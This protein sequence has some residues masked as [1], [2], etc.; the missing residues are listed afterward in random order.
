M[1]STSIVK[2]VAD[3]EHYYAAKDNYYTLEEGVEQSE[4]YGKGSQRLNLQ[5]EVNPDQFTA[6]LKG[7]LPHG[8]I[9]GKI[10]DGKT[11]HRAG[12]DLTFSAPKSVSI[13]ALV[14][15]DKRLLAAHRQAVK[16]VLSDIER[17]CSEVRIKTHGNIAY[18]R[19]S[20]MIAALFHH[21]L[22]RAEDPQLHTHSVIMNL[23]ER[24]DGKWRSMS[25]KL[26][27]YDK[28]STNEI[29]GFI[30]RVRHSKRFY[31]KMYETELAYQVQQLGYEIVID[32]KTGVFQIEGISKEILD[33]F[34][35]R[36]QKIE[37]HMQ[38]QGFSGQKSAEIA[39][40]HTR[41][42]KSHVN[43]EVLLEKWKESAK[44]L[45]FNGS[46]L[47]KEA[48]Q[49]ILLGH[50]Q[51]HNIVEGTSLKN[52]QDS[53]KAITQ[54]KSTFTLDD[55]LAETAS[56]VMKEA[57]N[58]QSFLDGVD[59]LIEKGELLS[60]ENK[61]GKSFFMAKSTLDDEKRI[62]TFLSVK[63]YLN[64]DQ[65]KKGFERF[66]SKNLPISTS[67]KEALSTILSHGEN[68]ESGKN[69]K[70]V[71]I[72][73]QHAK[74]VLSKAIA[75]VAK[76][77]KWSLTIVSPNQISSKEFAL[78]LKQAPGT[79]FEKLKSLFVDTTI[80]H[81]ST[82]Q[83]LNQEGSK[84]PDIL[85]ID[86]AHLL[87]AKEQA[88]LLEWGGQQQTKL[89]FFSQKN[90]LLSQKVGVDTNY[91]VKHGIS[92]VTLPEKT[93]NTLNQDISKLDIT[94][95]IHKMASNIIDV[96][97][98][99][100]RLLAMAT[101]FVSL[102]SSK[103]VF[104]IGNNKHTVETLNQSAHRELRQCGKLQQ[105][106]MVNVLLP[107][108]VAENKQHQLDS[109]P[110]GHVIRL[111]DNDRI[112]HIRRGEYL[113]IIGQDRDQKLLLLK[114]AK[115][116]V[117]KWKPNQKVEL[118]K[119]Q[120]IEW[121]VGERL[122]SQ[123]SM[124]FT[125]VTKGEYFTISH[126]Q[127][128]KVKLTRER[129]KPL[130]LDVSKPYHR[131]FNYGYAATPHQLVHKK[132]DHF[133]ADLTASAFTTDQ[134]RFFQLVSQPN[135]VSLY[136]DDAKAL[137]DILNKKSGNKLTA[138]EIVQSSEDVRKNLSSL[139][140][141]LTQAIQKP[142]EN[143]HLLPKRAVEA[144]D[145]AIQHLAERHAGF[146]H[147]D[148]L[149]VAMTHAI[150]EVNREQLLQ[151]FQ[152]MEQA[153]ILSQKRGYNGTLWTTQ[154]AIKIEQEILALSLKDKGMLQPIIS[155]DTVHQFL[156][157]K[158]LRPE[159]LSAIKTITQ[160]HDRVLVIQGRAGTG[161]TTMMASLADI[162]SAKELIASEGYRLQGIAPTHKAVKELQSRQIPAQTIDRFLLEMRQLQ[163]SNMKGGNKFNE[164]TQDF[165][166]TILI[167]D[168]ASMVSNKKMLAILS[169]VH[170]FNFRQVIPTGDTEQLAAIEAGKPHA[171]LQR[172][173][174][175]DVIHLE[176]IQRQ[177][178]PILK[179]AVYELYK[180]EVKNTFKI[181]GDSVIEIN[182]T[183]H[184]KNK[185]IKT[186]K[187]S[188]ISKGN[189]SIHPENKTIYQARVKALVQDYLQQIK[190]SEEVQIITPSHEDRKAV[191]AEVRNQLA[192]KG[193][194]T[195]DSHAFR[196]L[197]SKDMTAIERSEI[198]NFK[199]GQILRFTASQGKT[200]K[201]GEYFVVNSIDVKH[202]GFVLSKVSDIHHKDS[203]SG[204]IFWR[205]PASSKRMNNTI[206][207]FNKEERHLK[208]GD[209]IVWVR[210]D[211][212]ENILSTDSA[213]VKEI[214]GKNITV[215]RSDKSIFTFDAK[216]EKYQHWD[217]A[218]AITAYG[219]Q[220]GT[221]S[222]VLALFESYRK[223][224]MNLKTFLVT[225][226]RA[227]NHLRIYTDHKEKLID[228]I[229]RNK[230]DKL[231]SL[232][233]IGKYPKLSQSKSVHKDRDDKEQQKQEKQEKQEKQVEENI[234]ANKR[235]EK[236]LSRGRNQARQNP[237]YP[238][239]D[240]NRIKEGLNQQAEKLAI[241]IMGQ[242]KVH[243]GSYLK[244]GSNKGSLSVTIKGEKAG[245]WNDFADS[246]ANGRSMLSFI[247]KQCGMSKREAIVYA[248]R[249]LGITPSLSTDPH[250]TMI[251][252][253]LKLE[254]AFS[255]LSL[256]ET[257][258]Q[259]KMQ[260]RAKKIAQESIS[261]Q[262]TLAEKY[263]KEYR[264]IESI[265]GI[266]AHD[267]RFHPGVYSAINKQKLP[268]L[269]GI[270]RNH[271]NEILAVEATYLDIKTG[272]KAEDLM[273]GKQTFGAKKGG[274]VLIQAGEP[275]APTLLTEGIVT[276]LSVAKALPNVTVK[277]VLGIKLFKEIDPQLLSSKVVFALDNDGNNLKTDKLIK[278]AATRLLEHKK[279]V[280]FMVP[281]NIQTSKY[282]YN[283]VLTLKGEGA[284]QHDFKQA[285]PYHQ[286]YK[287]VN[288]DQLLREGIKTISYE[289]DKAQQINN[290]RQKGIS[291][292]DISHFANAMHK[293]ME[294]KNKRINLGYEALIDKKI[295]EHTLEI[296]HKPTQL[297]RDL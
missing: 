52:I 37:K 54:F 100:T 40:L 174:E 68:G 228:Q 125:N 176:D 21:D 141:I 291:T 76:Q 19:T 66:I 15:G 154:E 59:A 253:D 290:I 114:S 201:A 264:G 2:N 123:R 175:K 11:Y 166:K 67:E 1:L 189:K 282:D 112:S 226:T 227:Q 87:S 169:L 279:E 88:D 34:S 182:D 150:G 295:V 137:F 178:N 47:I 285:A 145:Y 109:Y 280:S 14:A 74:E 24:A 185:E 237:A 79:L 138:H 82:I 202:N 206:E 251:K 63:N 276:G 297:E 92:Q 172:S 56:G 103:N 84:A 296:T 25:S 246:E 23:T 98:Q 64:N 72:E 271:Q 292:E 179:E 207:V 149:E 128:T 294:D 27:R 230:G 214:N 211:K 205:L 130:L 121:S 36:R 262:G 104:L 62:Q 200:I 239:Y 20:N 212:K 29:H 45:D 170:E 97:E 43:R 55:L 53:I 247:E 57:H 131:H 213:E 258:H 73:G 65:L 28:E 51:N 288:S 220:G 249:W 157:H 210:T 235:T 217:H 50:K 260:A 199:A 81:A 195:G 236:S 161:K 193:F 111:L 209:K 153:G 135:N 229:G 13:M 126:I 107:Q 129:G 289:W 273:V 287:E 187:T 156:A 222:T 269:I 133:I 31:G 163:E 93:G 30:E 8:E 134:R 148:L 113:H 70:N 281:N 39:T 183:N 119:E 9:V 32:E 192:E 218:Y 225:I 250:K 194:L 38:E 240:I 147:K 90:V 117:F 101:H 257:E 165:N 248:A 256:N 86:N 233:V 6:L 278:E 91:L 243:G 266:T 35:K 188:K 221:Y 4:W 110:Q 244:F 231:S 164:L 71:L 223:N 224:L 136:T 159:Q 143:E 77:E 284:I 42:N 152:A 254:K 49:K 293:T 144:I 102:E 238:T 196:V 80:P 173:L 105:G 255:V 16:V 219:A 208:V 118:F 94:A 146:N 162:L 116:K 286:F 234:I 261:I 85:M 275:N 270:V 140:E 7:E 252:K 120:Q 33:L 265:E 48:E 184:N 99:E 283:D 122:Q 142:G 139:Y 242:P 58:L 115:G 46:S 245:W 41:E 263:L 204:T 60:L 155:Q 181:L 198:T 259:R 22:S 132:A 186:S 26:G 151:A 191:N 12:W 95:I 232:E 108:F 44:H 69:E 241:E 5:N 180:G 190:K 3:A 96:P 124:K 160:S 215:A 61:S 277:S 274:C 89:I 75:D 168:E 197:V 268:A 18:Q 17:G 272:S 106:I 216:N 127:G 177:K 167:V 78:D 203:Q 267:I 171:L 83:L 158:A 10:V